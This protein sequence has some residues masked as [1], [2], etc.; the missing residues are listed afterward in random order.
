MTSTFDLLTPKSIENLIGSWSTHVKSIIIVSQK[1]NELLCRNHFPQTNRQTDGRTDRQTAM[2][3]P[4]Y[5]PHKFVGRGYKYTHTL[6]FLFLWI[7]VT[8]ERRSI[9]C[10]TTLPSGDYLV[11]C[12]IKP[13]SICNSCNMFISCNLYSWNHKYCIITKRVTD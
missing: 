8:C 13:T 4:V 10:Y 1:E 7:G 9:T 3:T 2:A 5:H 11:K 12:P 6:R